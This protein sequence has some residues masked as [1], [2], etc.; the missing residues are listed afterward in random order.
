MAEEGKYLTSFLEIFVNTEKD[1]INLALLDTIEQGTYYHEYFHYIQDVTT[2]SGLSKIWNGF[3]RFRQLIASIMPDTITE[4]YVPLEGPIVSEQKKHMDFLE[5]LRGSGQ[6]T[7]VTLE[8]ANTY[9]IS[10]VIC[11]VD[12]QIAEYFPES[13]AT[14][15]KLHLV[16]DGNREKH[17]LFGEAAISETMAFL[18][19]KKFFPTLN[20][21]PKY[22]YQV[23]RDLAE[24]IYPEILQF[25]E[26]IFALCDVSL[27]HNMPGWAFFEI[28]KLMQ[29]EKVIPKSGEEV[30][31]FGYYFY[32][33][34][35]W[36][37]HAYMESADEALQN[38][39]NQLFGHS[40][41]ESTK[42]LFQ[43]SIERGRLLRFNEPYAV[44][45]IYK[46]SDALSY[47][48]YKAFNFLGGPHA[49]NNLGK[50]FLRIPLGMEDL[51]DSIHPQHFRVIWQLSKFLL[52]GLRACSLRSM[53]EASENKIEVDDRCE[54]FPWKRAEDEFGCPYAAFWGLYN[55]HKKDFY[56]NGVLIQQASE[57]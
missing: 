27:L 30:I 31:Q 4:V 16:S 18:I 46:S 55:F 40:H 47:N 56:L 20:N 14:K 34:K 10:E 29:Q 51:I 44:L 49:V 45:N 52:D 32:E 38:I 53:C 15:I 39:S 24:F 23:A 1:L 8:V 21:L 7:D 43:A 42:I 50:R 37:F 35:K 17:F 28:L 5:D 12:P 9:K 33:E 26:N 25:E 13:E 54:N 36:D 19:E 2:C 48:F 57:D 22:P 3:D 41:F 11:E 6:I